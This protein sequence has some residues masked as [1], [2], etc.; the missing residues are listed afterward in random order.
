[1][2]NAILNRIVRRETHTPRTTAMFVVVLLL[3]AALVYLAVEEI[4]HLSGVGPLLWSPVDMVA[5][6]SA[7]PTEQPRG[8]VAVGAAVVVLAGIVLLV[9]AVA[10]GRRSRHALDATDH[11][12]LVDNG[13]IASALSRRLSEETGL[14]PDAIV[15]GVGHRTADVTVKPE[16]GWSLDERHVREIADAEI[17]RYGLSPS[18]K[19]R[20]R[21]SRAGQGG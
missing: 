12:V 17:S 21:I 10:P 7:L 11:A 19:T 14:S 5:W 20:V 16:T 4:L 15:V 18:L 6:A 2:S 13:V 3:A 8:A 9:L 1:M